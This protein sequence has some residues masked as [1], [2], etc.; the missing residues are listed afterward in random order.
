MNV[1][2]FDG[3][4]YDGDS[5]ADFIMY[6]IH[7]RPKVLLNAPR[8][9]WAYILYIFG[10]FSQTCFK[11]EMYA[12]FRY[13]SDIDTVISDFWE[14]H[15]RKIKGWYIEQKRS[16]DLVISASPEFLLSPVCENLMASRVDKKTGKYTGE[17]CRGEE[18]VRRLYKNI[19][20]AVIEEFYSDSFAD[21]PLSKEAKKSFFVEGDKR[22]PWKEYTAKKKKNIISM[23]WSREFMMFVIIGVINT[24]NGI[25]LSWIYSL[26]IKNANLAFAV[27]YV[28]STVISYL[29]NS[30]FTFLERL[31]IK[32][33]LKFFVSY[34]PNFIIQNAAV[35]LFYNILAL[36][37]LFAYAIAAVI[38]VPLTFVFMKVF[39]FNKKKEEKTNE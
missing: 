38:G 1:Y 14:T 37:K 2:D 19:P 21:T 15:R 17:N 18:K 13:I 22:T 11:E 34:I 25:V 5:T 12:M 8:T 33:Y 36:N 9:L 29:L 10:V 27:G 16:D 3:T 26:F 31:S 32:R 6:C 35:I 24:F 23:L 4:I 20:D 7:H 30:K 39:T 28:T